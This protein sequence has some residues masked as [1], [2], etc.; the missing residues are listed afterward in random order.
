MV[1]S[2]QKLTKIFNIIIVII[3]KMKDDNYIIYS[4]VLFLIIKKW[5]SQIIL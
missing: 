3:I 1:T 5:K 2:I 4:T